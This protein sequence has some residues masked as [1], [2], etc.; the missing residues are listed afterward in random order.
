MS[1]I[2]LIA[3]TFR[4]GNIDTMSVFLFHDMKDLFMPHKTVIFIVMLN[5][6]LLNKV[7]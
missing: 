6:N 2:V 1:N 4:I 3:H 5:K 7:K